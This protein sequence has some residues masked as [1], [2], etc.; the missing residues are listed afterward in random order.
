VEAEASARVASGARGDARE[1]VNGLRG[2]QP[3]A[4][5]QVFA[6]FAQLDALPGDAVI[7]ALEPWTG[8]APDAESLSN[9]LRARIGLPPRR[10]MLGAVAVE[11]IAPAESPSADS[12]AMRNYSDALVAQIAAA[13]LTW[14]GRDLPAS[15]R[16]GFDGSGG[17]SGAS[18]LDGLMRITVHRVSPGDGDAETS[19]RGM[20]V[21]LHH[22]LSG[23]VFVEGSADIIGIVAEGRVELREARER[24]ALQHVLESLPAAVD[25]ND[26][27]ARDAERA[28]P[29]DAVPSKKAAAARKSLGD[30]AGSK[31]RSKV[32]ASKK[33]V[34]TPEPSGET[35]PSKAKVG[36]SK[37]AVAK[38]KAFSEKA[39]TK[40]KPKVVSSS[41]MAVKTK[42]PA[43]EAASKATVGVSKKPVAKPKA[44]SEKAATK[45][46]PK[47]VSSSKAAV[48]KNASAEK[49]PPK[50]KPKVASPKKAAATT[51][52][53]AVKA[54]SKAKAK[55]VASKKS[56]AQS[57]AS[58]KDEASRPKA[59]AASSKQVAKKP[60]AKTSAS[61]T[62]VKKK[63][64]SRSASSRRGPGASAGRSTTAKRS[65]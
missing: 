43:E 2:P 5:E 55:G 8:P 47:V 63:N 15:A 19:R 64:S 36:A 40:A 37:K 28:R 39:V 32:A 51:K 23:V 54:P 53:S 42:A 49:A 48:K 33:N 31:T 58:V 1:I 65:K 60:P 12:F 34:E 27:A 17:G 4:S 52:A 62:T 14:D 16:L 3:V 50:A 22:D 9:S 35:A 61:K 10:V 56:A 26:A 46:K 29:K 57:R 6:S 11:R 13:G 7:A 24:E 18:V 41:K 20:D 45:A 59:K 21:L 38:A 30:K 25:P 44:S